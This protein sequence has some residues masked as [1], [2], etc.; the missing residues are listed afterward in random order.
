MNTNLT[1]RSILTA[2]VL[3]S[4]V[5]AYALSLGPVSGSAVVG[6]PLLLS[7]QI[8]LDDESRGA[9]SACATAEVMYGERAIPASSVKVDVSAD[10]RLA[11]IS[12]PTPVDE[13]FVTLLLHAGCGMQST[14]RY[15]L[16]ADAQQGDDIVLVAATSMGFGSGGASSPA[17]LASRSAVADIAPATA[18]ARRNPSKQA[19]LR[20]P[21]RGSSGDVLPA[22]AR[23]QLAMWE[24]GTEG[25][26]WL[27]ASTQLLSIP[28]ADAAHRAAAT[29][30]WRAL[31]A[32]PQD[33]LRTAERL[34]GLEGEVV[35]L[36]G[37]SAR[38]R[39]EISSARE[40]L[41]E[42]RTQH[43]SNLALVMTL[44]LLAGSGAALFWHRSR[45]AASLAPFESWYPPLE[46]RLE[47]DPLHEE[48]QTAAKVA[49]PA[50]QAPSAPAPVVPIAVAPTRTIAGARAEPA[51]AILAP[52]DF[53]TG[54]LALVVEGPA[55]DVAPT[56]LKV[57]ALHDAQQQSEFFA[58]L[59]QFDEAVA[60]LTGYLEESTDEPVLAYL[61]LF[62][63]YH[64][65]ERRADYEQLQSAFRAIF[66]IG[67]TGFDHYADERR[68]LELYPVAVSRIAACWPSEKSLEVIEE[69]LFK[70]PAAAR[71]LLS[72]DAYRELV[73]L[74]TLG[75]DIA[76]STRM[77]AGLQLVGGVDLPN[78]HFILP[79]EFDNGEG[80]QELSLDRLDA[81][82][83]AHQLSGFAVDIDLGAVH[84]DA[85]HQS[86]VDER[87]AIDKAWDEEAAR[88]PLAAAAAPEA[89]DA[90][91]E[92]MEVHSRKNAR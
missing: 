11:R 55:A 18:T 61:E 52:F 4:G 89:V 87:K 76:Q 78:D 91:D 3:G 57:D 21:S 2:A 75:Q 41:M 60:V 64:G 8:Q 77:P 73:W 82:D 12:S 47:P 88:K 80:P 13:P 23:L 10:G 26:P 15:V 45:R 5:A 69:L 1:I 50:V 70:R 43:Y 35:S 68:E 9:S 86:R 37:L 67:F 14:R 90:F 38:H 56:R 65:L 20:S 85:M 27:R 46:P 54:K 39:S 62:R 58:S 25:S 16:L 28:A 74:Y 34:R 53:S 36:R 66:G 84:G 6:R 33:L 17:S 30:L 31:N 7:A 92:V 32:R 83:V 51:I 24:P 48:E 79:W 19:A 63:I 71:E 81:I 29:A 49:L 22:T 72:L 40:S 44:A 42:T 59:G